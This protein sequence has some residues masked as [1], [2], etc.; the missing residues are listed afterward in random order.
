MT[1]PAHVDGPVGGRADR[2]G[3][4]TREVTEMGWAWWLGLGL[5]PLLLGVL[6]RSASGGFPSVFLW[7]L[8][9]F[10]AGSLAAFG[11]AARF[12][13]REAVRRAVVDRSP[14]GDVR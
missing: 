1:Q 2:A 10:V 12:G 14:R 8:A 5:L 3:P 9:S 13:G 6:G 4:V 11:V 7:A